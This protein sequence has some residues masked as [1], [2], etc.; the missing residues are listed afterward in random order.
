MGLKPWVVETLNV[1][2]IGTAVLIGQ[3]MGYNN[4]AAETKAKME[5]EARNRIS[6]IEATASN[7]G[8]ESVLNKA[9]TEKQITISGIT[10]KLVPETHPENYK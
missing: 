3:Y 6:A 8:L 2:V 5:A 7:S 1:A 10:Y 9:E 4:G